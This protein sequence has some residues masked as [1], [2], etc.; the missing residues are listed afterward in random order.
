MLLAP[1]ANARLFGVRMG[2]SRRL[3]DLIGTIPKTD[4]CVIIA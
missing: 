1:G 2:W 4:Y 3:V